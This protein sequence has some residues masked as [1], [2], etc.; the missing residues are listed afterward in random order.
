MGLYLG[1]LLLLF[2]TFSIFA[3]RDFKTALA[4][5]AF[6]LPTY[7][8]RFSLGPIP[9]TVLEGFILILTIL[10]ITKHGGIHTHLKNLDPFIRP[11][12]LLL[13]AACFAVVVAPNTLEALNTWKSYFIEPL[14]VFLMLRTTFTHEDDWEQI[15]KF[16][17]WSVIALSLFGIIQYLTGLALP[18]PWDIERRITSIF[19]YP[20]ALGLYLAPLVG[21][22][23]V[24]F[25]KKRGGALWLA[26]IVLGIIGIIL[27]QTE[28]ALVAIPAGLL[29]T[30]LL[31]DISSRTKLRIA[32]EATVIGLLLV[33]L[34]P[35]ISEKIF[36][37]D[38]SGQVRIAQWQETRALI[39]DN[40]AFGAG[41]SGYPQ[42]IAPYHDFRFYEV[43][44]Y[45]HN[46]FLN[47]WV[48]LG[49][50]G[51]IAF[52]WLAWLMLKKTQS[53]DHKLVLASFAALAIMTIHGLVDVPFFK[54]DLS[55]MTLI[56]IAILSANAIRRQP[57]IIH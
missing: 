13:A 16:F 9:F 26:S 18:A 11:L 22:S 21:M 12:L 15:P 38:Y 50:L 32:F 2:V 46:I 43:F 7:L 37:Q 27:A 6:L 4:S 24:L 25:I 23:I 31:T 33:S 1:V 51:L 52:F 48:E 29:I 40:P 8:L 10:W 42:A 19:P 5:L 20:N 35:I 45:P 14:L 53:S 49:I 34:V 17:A 57:K 47:I 39:Q 44:Q 3:W 55:V 54:N 28:A 56:F 30:L 41:L 36:L